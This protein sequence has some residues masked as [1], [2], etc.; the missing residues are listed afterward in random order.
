[1][2]GPPATRSSPSPQPSLR[3][4]PAARFLLR[5]HWRR[6][7]GSPPDLW[8]C[9]VLPSARKPRQ[10]LSRHPP[11][12]SRHHPPHSLDV[13]ADALRRAEMVVAGEVVHLR[14]S[15]MGHSP[16]ADQLRSLALEFLGIDRKSV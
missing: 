7:P 6:S 5:L 10:A 4:L 13:A 9:Q 12:E 8:L 15:R 14:I 3:H 2:T 16:G 1:G 11:H